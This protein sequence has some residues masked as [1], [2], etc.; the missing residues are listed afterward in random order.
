MG[1]QFAGAAHVAELVIVAATAPTN[2]AAPIHGAPDR[3]LDEPAVALRTLTGAAIASVG[4]SLPETVV[5]SA[6][7]AEKFGVDVD[8]IVRR[9]GI[10]E[11]RFASAEERLSAHA[12]LAAARALERASVSPAAVDLVLVATVT[13]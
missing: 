2:G 13:P 9:T 1:P 12:A 8:W 11:R 10:H 4:A 5:P 3:A 6:Q 7:I